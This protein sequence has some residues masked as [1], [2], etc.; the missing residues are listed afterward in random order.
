MASFADVVSVQ[1]TENI[2]QYII[3]RAN[4]DREEA[5]QVDAAAGR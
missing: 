2:R 1:D 5:Q 4:I 3:S